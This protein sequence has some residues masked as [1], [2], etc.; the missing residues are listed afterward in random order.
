MSQTTS[1]KLEA[2]SNDFV[3]DRHAVGGRPSLGSRPVGGAI[4]L[5][6]IKSGLPR[7]PASVP[8]NGLLQRRGSS[9]VKG[10]PRHT[11]GG[12]PRTPGKSTQQR[13]PPKLAPV[14][15]QRTVSRDDTHS[16]M[17][18]P[19]VGSPAAPADQGKPQGAKLHEARTSL[20]N[21][22]FIRQ[23]FDV[24]YNCL[25]FLCCGYNIDRRFF[26]GVVV[27]RGHFFVSISFIP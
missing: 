12:Q 13:A 14:S 27:V 18:S 16:E 9:H 20:L 3:G 7:S 1:R 26:F 23:G 24:G 10:G 19:V 11:H 4:S 17:C 25:S 2:A 5:P 21:P 15:L 8:T 22:Y 6:P